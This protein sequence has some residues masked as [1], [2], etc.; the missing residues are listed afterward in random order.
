VASWVK[1]K[2]T[3][4]SV[5]ALSKLYSLNDPRLAQI[6]VKGDLV[7]NANDGQIKTRSRAK[8]SMSSQD[9]TFDDMGSC[10]LLEQRYQEYLI[11]EVAM[12]DGHSDEVKTIQEGH[13]AERSTNTPTATLDPDQY[14]VVAAPLK[15]VKLLIDELLSA[16]GAQAASTAAAA[17]MSAAFDDDDEDG[18]EDDDDTLDLGLSSTKVDL[19]SYL[20]GP[21]RRQPDDETQTFLTEF[22]IRCGRENVA[23]FQDWYSM[24]KDDEKQKLNELATA[25]Q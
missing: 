14:T 20:E 19:M 9:D 24:L 10:R 6:S 18:W 5:I 7:I 17:A 3:L 23:N 16:S 12:N 21:G 25:T 4:P 1:K 11:G 2:L 22:F 13:R 8:Q 15:I